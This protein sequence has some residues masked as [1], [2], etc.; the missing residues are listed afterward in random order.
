MSIVPDPE[1]L[2]EM[3]LPVPIMVP[4]VISQATFQLRILSVAVDSSI[5]HSPRLGVRSDAVIS[6]SSMQ[7]E[8]VCTFGAS[9]VSDEVIDLISHWPGS[10]ATPFSAMLADWT[11]REARKTVIVVDIRMKA[12]ALFRELG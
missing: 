11:N 9:K 12:G 3:K 2:L 10:I 1:S 6:D 5:W 8:A 4:T 7:G